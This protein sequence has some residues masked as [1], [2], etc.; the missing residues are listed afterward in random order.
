MGIAGLL[1]GHND[2]DLGNNSSRRLTSGIV[3]LSNKAPIMWKFTMQ[4]TTALCAALYGGSQ[5]L[6]RIGG[7]L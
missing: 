3:A 2:A 7:W 4:E 6:L 1:S 5:A